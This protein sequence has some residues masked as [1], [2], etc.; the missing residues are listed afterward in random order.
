MSWVK[1]DSQIAARSRAAGSDV[2]TIEWKISSNGPAELEEC[3]QQVGASGRLEQ[4]DGRRAHRAGSNGGR[5][6]RSS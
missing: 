1:I 5:R 4:A 6:T 3:R 2:P